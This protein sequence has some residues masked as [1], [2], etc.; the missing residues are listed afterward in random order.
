MNKKI[1]ALAVAAAF[2]IPAAASAQTT[3]FGQFK[4]EVGAI[5]DGTDRNAVHSTAGTRLGVR[6]SEDLGGGLK[7]IFRFQGSFS[8]ANAPLGSNDWELNEE[9]WV[10]LQGGFGTLQ[11]GRSNTAYK[12]GHTRFRIFDD[13][14]ADTSLRPASFGRAEG[15]HYSSPNFGGLVV[16]ATVEPN[17][18]E[19]DAYYAVGA[20]WSAGP[21]FVSAAFESAADTGLYQGGGKQIVPDNSNWQ[22]G[23][24]YK[25]SDL[26]VG[27][28]YQ[29]VEDV[30]TWATIPVTYQLGKVGLKATVQLRDNEDVGG[31]TGEDGV[32]YGLGAS[33]SFSPRTE[34]IVHIWREG[35]QDVAA[36]T[37]NGA[38]EETQLGLA[39]RHS[40]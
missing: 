19:F 15:V 25:L 14:L 23:A 27:L 38:Q 40:F 34:A 37:F 31:N 24:S 10:G 5:E 39:V 30:A 18:N 11:L 36:S 8:G 20:N 28:L 2:A 4:Y 9:N 21:L 1:V 3:L 33:Y 17:G 12:K 22:V 6:G 32:N 7:G 35:D 26:T 13:S 29:D 16:N